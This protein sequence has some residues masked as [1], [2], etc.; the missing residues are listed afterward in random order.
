MASTRRPPPF[1]IYQDHVSYAGDD[2][3][4]TLYN[5][6][7]PL[8]NAPSKHNLVLEP[9]IHLASATSPRKSDRH[10]SSPAGPLGGRILHSVSLPP[11]QQPDFATDS[12]QKNASY[13]VQ[14]PQVPSLPQLPHETV[15]SDFPSTNKMDKE[16]INMYSVPFEQQQAM[17]YGDMNHGYK[18]PTKRTIQESAPLRDRS[19]NKRCK[20]EEGQE[21]ISLPHPQEMPMVEDDGT[22]PSHSYATLIGMAILRAPNR[23][24][25]LAQIYKWISDNFRFYK[26]N[27][28]GWQNSIRHNLSLHKA[29]KK[30]ERPKDDPGK[31][32]YWVIEPG[33]EAQFLKDRPFNK[34]MPG[35][36]PAFVQ[37]HNDFGSIPRPAS[38]PAIGQFTL[39][40]SSSKRFESKA[41]DSS[42][43]PDET[44][45]SDGT[46]PAS[47]PAL[48]DDEQHDS[49]AMPPPAARQMRSSP[50]PA[51]IGSS[52]PPMLPET[53]RQGTP[54]GLPTSSRIDAR[55]RNTGNMNDSGYYSSIESSVTR[56][57]GYAHIVPTSEADLDHRRL[58]RGRAEEEIA[59]IRSSSYDSPSKEKGHSKRLSVHFETS[60][61]KRPESS[62]GLPPLTPGV[63][64]K[65]PALPPASISPNTNLRDHRARMRKLLGDSPSKNMMTPLREPDHAWGYQSHF[66]NDFV[67]PV[68]STN[69][70]PWRDSSAFDFF[71][72][73]GNDDFSA[74]GSPAKRP[75]IARAVTSTGILADI[76]GNSIARNDHSVPSSASTIES[77]F[78][79]AFSPP[80]KMTPNSVIPHSPVRLGSPLKR[81]T[82]TAPQAMAPPID[83]PPEWLDL[84]L[85]PLF[86]IAGTPRRQSTAWAH[87][88]NDI[89]NV[90][91]PSDAS[92]E[93]F[94]ILQE[95]GKIGAHIGNHAYAQPAPAPAKRPARPPMGRSV[96]SRF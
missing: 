73:P 62:S 58:K 63:I 90:Q 80:F 53:V 6:L 77:P 11:P 16:N 69:I 72:Y 61:P 7:G 2:V 29:F 35:D 1:N 28:T 94:D 15:Y 22:K 50:P 59:R 49:L 83:N 71:D 75:K 81:S 70:T 82:T 68:K 84:S 4:T 51:D 96:T 76:T 86:G 85:D 54:T 46:I 92:E 66:D 37:V 87:G 74:R 52:P 79:L 38:T 21:Q 40:P 48:Q 3:E 95:F 45:S 57:P 8:N 64:F 39:A 5:A 55:K 89:F 93:G 23:R 36:T 31:G 25:T 17:H 9:S 41:I 47:D 78:S 67:S 13:Y 18:G 30:Q 20:T 33:K 65:R 88:D 56:G 91:P 32:N 44:L 12:P 19:N 42:K 43:F 14:Y 26:A 60:S 10:S 27:E 24:L 34:M